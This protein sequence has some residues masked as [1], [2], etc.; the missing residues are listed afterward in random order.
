MVLI[1]QADY[2]R[3]FHPLEAPILLLEPHFLTLQYPS[4]LY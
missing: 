4:Q 1:T 2:L 3:P